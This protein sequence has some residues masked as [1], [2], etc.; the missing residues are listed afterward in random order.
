MSR[1]REAADVRAAKGDT[2]HRPEKPRASD[3]TAPI[4]DAP[5]WL[6]DDMA[7]KAWNQL[8][9]DMA[10]SS[11]LKRADT[12]ILGRYCTYMAE[13]VTLDQKLRKLGD[14][15]Y[16]TDT[17]HGKM[18]RIHPLFLARDRTESNLVKMEDSLGLTPRAR[19]AILAHLAGHQPVLPGLGD[20]DH[21]EAPRGDD[22]SI[23]FIN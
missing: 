9:S 17:K 14:V 22:D 8:C 21:S 10:A 6:T 20:G 16:E 12:N 1:P 5:H 11:L 7:L 19:I 2:S 4:I 18:Q 3:A 15:V 13:W 23:A